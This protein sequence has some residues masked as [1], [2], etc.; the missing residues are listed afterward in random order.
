MPKKNKIIVNCP[1]LGKEEE[2]AVTKILRSGN[3][4]QGEY[5]NLFEEKFTE[6]IG[7]KHAVATSSGTTAL[8]LTLLALGITRGD[9]VIT[10][11]FSFI[12]SANS[13]LFTGAKPVFVDIDEKTFN[14]CPELIEEKITPRTK[15]ILP[16]HLFG[17]PANMTKINA[18]AQKHQ[19]LVIEDACQAHGAEIDRKKA[20][21]MGTVGCFSFYPTKNM[22]TGEGGMVTT[23]DLKLAKKIKLLRNHGMRVRYHH[24][25]LGYNFRL[26]NIAAAI[27]LEQLKKLPKFNNS[28]IKNAEYLNKRLPGIKGLITPYVP[29]GYK[30]VFHQYTIKI[31][32]NYKMTRELLIKHLEN[33]GISSAIYYPIPIHQQKVYKSLGYKG[34]LPVCEKLST[35]VLSLPVHPGLR[36]RDLTTIASALI[37]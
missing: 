18:I 16:V 6:Y 13:I 9:E 15:A 22:T 37:S 32:D 11:P 19:L 24:E 2:N 27:G 28:R 36:I 35:Q 1:S 21:S 4:A 10:T 29:P 23:N 17:L 20:G 7:V 25:V 8:H 31:N 3:L 5:V 12:A 26:T 30:H 34:R 33:Q 14:L